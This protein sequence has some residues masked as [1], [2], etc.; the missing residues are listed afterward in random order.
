MNSFVIMLL[1]AIGLFLLFFGIE[2][3]NYNK[4]LKILIEKA[5]GA[6]G[7]TS[8]KKVSASE[9]E[10][11]KKMFYRYMTDDS[12]DDITASDLD[13][14]D[15][16]TKFNV[17]LSAPGS[18]YFYYLLRTPEFDE[19]K[20]SEFSKKVSYFEENEEKRNYLR[21]LFL[22]I[23]NMNRVNFFECLD[24]FDSL[25]V[26]SLVKDFAYIF[27]VFASIA[28][29]FFVP[30]LGI[31]LLVTALVLSILDYYKE[32]G[33][34]ESYII[35]FAYIAKFI[36]NSGSIATEDFG[37]ANDEI[38]AISDLYKELKPFSNKASLLGS[39]SSNIGAGNPIEILMDYVRM[40]FHADIIQFY[41]MLQFLK[42]KKDD[43]EKL[44]LLIGRLESFITVASLRTAVGNTVTPKFIKGSSVKATEIYHPLIENPV[45]NS[46]VFDK[47]V[48]ITG[49]NA[50]GKSTFLKTLALNIIF[51]NTIYT[52]F[53][54]EMVLPPL[55]VFSSMSLRDD[56][57]NKDSYFM[58]EIKALKRIFDFHE[59]YPE[60]QIIC[61][62]DEVLRG[63]NTVERIAACTE[64]LRNLNDTGVRTVAATHDIELT[65]LL[66][67]LYDNYHF[68]EDVVDDDVLFNYRIKP[69]KAT[70]KNAIKL[71]SIM[72]FSKGIVDK[73]KAMA[74]DFVSNGKWR[75]Q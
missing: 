53:A 35:C 15:I 71:L 20:L 19:Y 74:D 4:N 59:K 30:G 21:G 51:A 62:V 38:E 14:D 73:A 22:S 10:N 5:N 68:D 57:A 69:G 29:I 55:Y 25:K 33:L 72:G 2:Y 36:K 12:I 1:G 18:E 43:I 65:D 52:C 32:R 13:I 9:M 44:Y 67:D 54:S 48:L 16:F 3:I 17:S 27:S 39:K 34:I 47:G 46:I 42:N 26:K 6:F 50:S 56:L 75:K 31:G 24:Y 41:G 66:N 45:V 28:V 70:S 40:I 64:I 23:G 37:P 63:T 60:K 49:S 61:F 7:K 11:I 8:S 58:V